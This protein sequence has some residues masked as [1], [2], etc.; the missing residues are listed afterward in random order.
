MSTSLKVK[1]LRLTF[2]ITCLLLLIMLK[3]NATCVFRLYL[4]YIPVSHPLPSFFYPYLGKN[5]Y[6]EMSL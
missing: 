5:I 6:L 4:K 1:V 3:E 2:K